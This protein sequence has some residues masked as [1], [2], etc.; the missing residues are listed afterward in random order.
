MN[1]P[2]HP[3]TAGGR[4]APGPA[5]KPEQIEP[6]PERIRKAPRQPRTI[7]DTHTHRAQIEKEETP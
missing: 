5:G 2:H 6:R 4:D 7:R 1:P 3:R